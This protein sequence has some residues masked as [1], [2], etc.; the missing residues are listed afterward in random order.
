VYSEDLHKIDTI[1]HKQISHPHGLTATDM[2][3]V[4]V[5][6]TNGLHEILTDHKYSRQISPG[7]YRDVTYYNGMV[8]GLKDKPKC[9]EA[10]T[11]T[12]GQLVLTQTIDI[13]DVKF[14]YACTNR[15]FI[16]DYTMTIAI[17]KTV[18]A[19]NQNGELLHTVQH[20]KGK[21]AGQFGEYQG[22]AF[23]LLCGIDCNSSHLYTNTRNHRVQVCD[24]DGQW[25]IIPLPQGIEFPFDVIVE[26]STGVMWL[27]CW[28]KIYKLIIG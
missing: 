17:Y 25:S 11:V 3:T 19:Y 18:Y 4:I 26:Q 22:E 21:E 14:T 8:Y 20:S 12:D 13:L 16:S 1:K 24:G 23:G 6:C 5:A 7:W 28:G 9:V 27:S 2:S 15:V 10:Y